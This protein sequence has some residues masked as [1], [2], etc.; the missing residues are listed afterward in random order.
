MGE[1]TG[2]K[3][4]EKITH[5][6]YF[7][8]DTRLGFQRLFELSH[9]RERDGSDYTGRHIAQLWGRP[10]P[11]GALWDRAACSTNMAKGNDQRTNTEHLWGKKLTQR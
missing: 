3:S 2:K 9:V 8:N 6:F 10:G 7:N 5:L 4:I 11:E 1:D